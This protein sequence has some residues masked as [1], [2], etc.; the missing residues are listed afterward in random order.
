[1]EMDPDTKL[2]QDRHLM[3]WDQLLG[4]VDPL[5]VLNDEKDRAVVAVEAKAEQE[6]LEIQAMEVHVEIYVKAYAT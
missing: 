4:F 6:G 2:L 1:M 5:M 3:T